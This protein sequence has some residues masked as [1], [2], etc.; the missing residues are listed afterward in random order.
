MLLL[1][2]N[3]SLPAV[4]MRS[5]PNCIMRTKRAALWQFCQYKTSLDVAACVDVLWIGLS[6]TAVVWS[7]LEFVEEQMSIKV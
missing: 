2:S 6:K 4:P 1:S 7:V 3:L 5:M